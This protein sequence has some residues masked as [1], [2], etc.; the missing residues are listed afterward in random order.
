MLK[1]I[2]VD[3]DNTLL[4]FDEYVKE[5]MKEGFKYFNLKEYEPYMFDVFTEENTKLWLLIEQEKLTLKELEKIRWNNIFK[6]LNIYFDGITFEKYFR[7]QLYDSTILIP[8]A[9]DMLD[10]LHNKYILCAASNG[11]YDQQL[12]RLEK[13]SLK[14]YF[15]YF[16]ISEEV[17]FSKPSKEFFDYAFK[18]IN[19][20]RKEKILPNETLIIGDSLTSDIKG[21]RN[22]GIKTCY[23]NQKTT[24]EEVD[25]Q[26]NDLEKI[27]EIL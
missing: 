22:Y 4:S 8:G 6:K 19:E 11:P 24:A 3:V 27:K 7:K 15:T 1:L 20:N 9:K 25:Y 12:H 17:G 23:Y 5:T 10:Y 16:F 14:N 18:K 26:I 21:G 2:F 13:A